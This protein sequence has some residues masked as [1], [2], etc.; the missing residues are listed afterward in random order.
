VRHVKANEK[1]DFEASEAETVAIVGES[2]CGKSTFAKVLMGL[3]TATE[4]R[5]LL[6]GKDIGKLDPCASAR[7]SSSARCRSSSRTPSRR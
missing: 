7:R 6:H 5:G 4:R 2:G 3:E 1:L